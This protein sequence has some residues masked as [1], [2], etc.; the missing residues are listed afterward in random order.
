MKGNLEIKRYN[1]YTEEELLT[2]LK[3]YANDNKIKN[4]SSAQ[5][6]TWMSISEGTI[7]RI[8]KTWHDFCKKAELEPKYNKR[9]TKELLFINLN[10]VWEEIGRQPRSKEMKQP[11][12]PISCSQYRRTFKKNWYEICLEFMSWKCSIPIEE[13]KLDL[14]ENNIE[15]SISVVHKT[16]R[17]INLSLR[18]FVLKRDNFRCVKCGDSPAL[19]IGTRLQV[20]HKI[21]W[22]KGGETE[23]SNLQT[24]CFNCNS[25][26]SNKY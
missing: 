14:A 16:N 1:T 9:T 4:I 3:K 26:K 11:L 20:D 21:P 12:S 13:I 15:K 22:E 10:K 23:E 8:F 18:Y 6:C 25:G 24:L 5:F 2:A 17:N 19:N 7:Q